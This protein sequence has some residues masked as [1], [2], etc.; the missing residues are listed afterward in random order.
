MTDRIFI[1]M[2]SDQTEVDWLIASGNNASSAR[3]GHDA[4]AK[5]APL[6]RD[7]QVILVVPGNSTTLSTATLPVTNKK[8]LLKAIP[9]ALEE[10][11]V[12]DVD[13]LHFAIGKQGIDKTTPVAV[14]RQQRMKNWIAILNKHGITPEII[15]PNTLLLPLK[16]KEWSA[17]V[18]NNSMNVR[19]GQNSGFSCDNTN[20]AF[21]LQTALVESGSNKPERINLFLSENTNPP[22]NL[23]ELDV[24]VVNHSAGKNPLGI[25]SGNI[26]GSAVINL[27]QGSFVSRK[28]GSGSLKPWK[29]ALIAGTILLLLHVGANVAQYFHLD[30][31]YNK[32]DA[33]I[34]QL[35]QQLFPGSKKTNNIRSLV[36]SKL[37]ALKASNTAGNNGFVKLLAQT[38]NVL[39]KVPGLEINNINYRNSRMEMEVVL[40]DLQTLEK[41]KK[42]LV[43][44]GL[45]IEV[46]SASAKDNKVTTRLKI[47]GAS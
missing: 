2:P 9:Y 20:A 18:Q 4:L 23:N 42:D 35:Y 28:S 26:N 14:T 15:I 21:M 1:Y 45:N 12:E 16:R 29:P 22:E 8:Q 6:C 47:E 37:K 36:Q 43:E 44:A 3:G 19:T 17:V 46:Q 32:L 34:T 40:S 38:G 24:E 27:M 11:L 30:N 7:R 10:Q 5:I 25:L 31:E 39:H 41:V 13:S 33:E